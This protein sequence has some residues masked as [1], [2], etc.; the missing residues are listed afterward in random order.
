MKA[1]MS[2]LKSRPLPYFV[3]REEELKVMTIHLSR[4]GVRLTADEGTMP[5]ALYG[6]EQWTTWKYCWKKLLGHLAKRM[7]E[8]NPSTN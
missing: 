7:I 2:L 8:K 5:M 3:P 1:V 6:Y 4:I